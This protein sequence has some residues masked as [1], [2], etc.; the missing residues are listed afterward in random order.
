ME[1]AKIDPKKFGL[2]GAIAAAVLWTIYSLKV[3]IL[4]FLAIF[5]FSD[6]GYV[7][8]FSLLITNRFS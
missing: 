8:I 3:L 7:G 5:L 4:T 2:S 6:F 1:K